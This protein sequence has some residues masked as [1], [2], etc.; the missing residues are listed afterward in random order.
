MNPFRPLPLFGGPHRQTLA[1]WFSL[2]EKPLPDTQVITIPL[3]EDDATTLHLSG[4]QG[5]DPA[6]P[7][8]VLMHG[9][10]GDA[11][12]P[13]LLRTARKAVAAGFRA[14]RLNM[15]CCGDGERLSK[16]FY[17][18]AQSEVI[19]ATAKWIKAS[20]PQSPIGLLGFSLGGNLALRAAAVEE[21][22]DLLGTVA[23]CPPVDAH[24]SAQTLNNWENRHYH[25]RFVSSMVARVQ[26]L[27]KRTAIPNHLPFSKRM[28]LMEF[29]SLFTVPHGGFQNLRHY[30]DT[31]S[32]RGLLEEIETPWLIIAA[33]DD[34]MVPFVSFKGM[35][36]HPNM[37]APAHGG[38]LGFVGPGAPGDPDWRWSE[39]RAIEFLS[40]LRDRRKIDL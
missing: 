6:I 26:R 31:C 40:G 17:H 38:H 2:P 28:T 25:Y 10:E 7:T 36:N 23:I 15:R 12:R 34:P 11:V 13:Y 14:A 22:P 30:Y 21:I 1:G 35:E 37:I 3:G 18:G 5:A 20:F 16:K 24:R 8:L 39:N 4:P 29:D 27:Q 9:L 33:R 32:T 19:A